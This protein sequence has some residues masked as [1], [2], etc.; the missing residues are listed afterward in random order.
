MTKE[1]LARELNGID[2]PLC[3]TR[4]QVK[5]AK[6]SGLVVVY[7]EP[8]DLMEL[9]GAI[10]EEIGCYTGTTIHVVNGEMVSF[11]C[12]DEYNECEHKLAVKRSAKTIEAIFDSEGYTWIYKTDIPHATFDIMEDGE[13]YCRGIV[14]NVRDTDI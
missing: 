9:E 14:F 12:G 4:E 6:E 8:Y 11:E 13:A 5:V 1:E 2:Y 7:G 3:M 10:S